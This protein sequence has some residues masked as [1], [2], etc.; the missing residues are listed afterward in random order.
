MEPILVAVISKQVLETP[1]ATA[2]SGL[3]DNRGGVLMSKH[4]R[5]QSLSVETIYF[6]TDELCHERSLGKDLH[7]GAIQRQA[8]MSHQAGS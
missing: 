6:T 1:K 3:T 2:V 5:A 7:R 4:F 8:E